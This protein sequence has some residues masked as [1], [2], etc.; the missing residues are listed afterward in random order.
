M[1]RIVSLP[2]GILAA[3]LLLVL[4]ACQ[5]T[6]VR[7][8]AEGRWEEIP[9]GSRLVLN[10]P[11]AIP[12]DRA[13]IFLRGGRLSPQGANLGPSCGIEIRTISRDGPHTI[14][15]GEFLIARVQQVWTEVA[16]REPP[17]AVRFRLASS[18]DAG[19]N[20]MIQ[21]GYHFWLSKGPDPDVMRLTCLGMLDE[22]AWAKPPTLDEIR[23][24]LGAVATLRLGA[25]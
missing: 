24:A 10:R 11:V 13:R 5:P 22:M 15:A 17:G 4:S 21:E 7:E 16:W 25:P 14:P 6:L 19:G 18:T 8:T 12:Q 23:E 2:I 1:D 9:P 3:T 20:P